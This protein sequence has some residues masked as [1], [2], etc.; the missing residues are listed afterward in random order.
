M[1]ILANFSQLELK[2]LPIYD[3]VSLIV[4]LTYVE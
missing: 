4:S 1:V 2:I 3:D